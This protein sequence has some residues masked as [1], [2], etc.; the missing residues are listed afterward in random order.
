MNKAAGIG[1]H[2]RPLHRHRIQVGGRI[3]RI[4]VRR[5]PCIGEEEKPIGQQ[6]VAG[7]SAPNSTAIKDT[8]RK[9][10]RTVVE[11]RRRYL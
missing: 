8:Q 11:R 9:Y 10:D 3:Q 7:G 4:R 1:S 2:R 6:R 5:N